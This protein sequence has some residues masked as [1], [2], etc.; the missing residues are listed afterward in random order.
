MTLVLLLDLHRA[1]LLI[2][3]FETVG[4]SDARI[5]VGDARRQDSIDEISAG[6]LDG[7][8]RRAT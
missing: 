7:G 6:Q 2:A 3:I 8:V 1:A 4:R 5:S